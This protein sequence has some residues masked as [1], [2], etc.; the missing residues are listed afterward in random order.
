MNV[1]FA[2][3]DKNFAKAERLIAEASKAGADTAVLPEMW[4]TG[5]FPKDNLQSLCDCDGKAVTE[6]I[7][8]LSSLYN[9]NIVAGSIANRIENKIYN[10]SY[11]FGRNGTFSGRYDKTHLFSMMNEDKF[12]EK[13]SGFLTFE[14]DGI[15]C[16]VIICYD[17]RFPEVVRYLA[18]QGIQILFVAAQWPKVRV[19]IMKSLLK[20]RAI[21]NQIFAVCCNSCGESGGIT[22]G[23]CSCIIDPFGNVIA[24]AKDYES[25]ISAEIDISAVDNIR[26][27]IDIFSDRRN[28]LY[29]L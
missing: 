13:G 7:G 25:V 23:G 14:I 28:D 8:K 19:E 12:F 6:R 11:V 16:G 2:S 5:F 1:S 27:E 29:K 26:K 21:E 24:S 9:V 10:S 18:L 17:L 22:F 20:A 4:N 3:P 15:R